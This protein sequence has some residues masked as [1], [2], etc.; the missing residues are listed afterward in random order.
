MADTPHL[1]WKEWS[2]TPYLG[3]YS[4]VDGKDLVLT[5]ARI[6]FEDVIGT[7]GKAQKRRICYFRENVK[8]MILN[9]T[10][11][12]AIAR[13][14]NTDLMDAW[15]GKQIQLYADP[16]VRFGGER[17]GGL[18]IRNTIPKHES[19]K[20]A[21]CGEDILPVGNM[22]A[23]QVAEYAKKTFGKPVCVI[24]GKKL[25]EE[26]ESKEEKETTNEANG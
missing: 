2:D 12:K 19:I 20:C 16:N 11:C 5:I 23:A 25:K 7:N 24:C 17:T 8:P 13:L 6:A 9:S 4:I 18:R 22:S 10:N 1:H 21:V 26:K 15:V 14:Y 3:S